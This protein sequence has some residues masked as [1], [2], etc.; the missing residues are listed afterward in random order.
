MKTKTLF[1]AYV[2]CRSWMEFWE[3]CR[4][5]GCNGIAVDAD[6]YAVKWQRYERLEKKLYDRIMKI[7]EENDATTNTI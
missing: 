6:E 7:F 3:M 5:E 1:E 4:D 2:S